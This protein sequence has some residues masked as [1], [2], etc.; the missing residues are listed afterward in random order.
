MDAADFAFLQFLKAR[1]HKSWCNLAEDNELVAA[2]QRRASCLTHRAYQPRV[3][4]KTSWNDMLIDL[5]YLSNACCGFLLAKCFHD[6]LQRPETPLN[7]KT[8]GAMHEL[9]RLFALFTMQKASA[10]RSQCSFFG[11]RH[12]GVS[13][14]QNADTG[15]SVVDARNQS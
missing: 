9:F 13:T 15:N 10:A 6:A 11:H 14:A 4:Q 8:L 3:V 7:A 5:H 12:S 1:E 2:F